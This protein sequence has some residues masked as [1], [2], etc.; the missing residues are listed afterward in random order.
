M[1]ADQKS[2]DR[3]TMEREHS[4]PRGVNLASLRISLHEV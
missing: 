1:G 2:K 4:L 3:A